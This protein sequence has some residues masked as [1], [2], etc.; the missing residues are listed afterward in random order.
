MLHVITVVVVF[1]HVVHP[2]L[3]Q[4]QDSSPPCWPKIHKIINK[5]LYDIFVLFS[6]AT[7]TEKESSV[8]R[9]AAACVRK[10]HFTWANVSAPSPAARSVLKPSSLVTPLL[11]T[12]CLVRTPLRLP[13]QVYSGTWGDLEG[14]I[15]CQMED[16]PRYDLGG[17]M[18]PRREV[19][20][21][22]A[23]GVAPAAAFDTPTKGTSVQK[24][25]E[26]IL[27][28]LKVG[29]KLTSQ[30]ECFLPNL[31]RRVASVHQD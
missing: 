21:A 31:F 23:A 9:P 14:V 25:R 24:F 5:F 19:G 10:T 27:N 15:K 6:S 26:M 29:L 2:L 4:Y 11:W 12:S 8:A 18:E 1:K 28:H 30:T 22:P 16:T 3:D 13:L 7:N 17:E 20:A